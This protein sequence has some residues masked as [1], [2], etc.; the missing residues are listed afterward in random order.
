MCWYLHM[1]LDKNPISF[2]CLWISSFPTPFIK[3]T[4]LFYYM[5]L[6]SLLRINRPYTHRFV[7]RFS[8]LFHWLMCLFL[9]WYQYG[10]FHTLQDAPHML[11][12]YQDGGRMCF[13]V[14]NDQDRVPP[15]RQLPVCRL[16]C[17]VSLRI[18]KDPKFV[19]QTKVEH[20]LKLQ[21]KY[22]NK[23]KMNFPWDNSIFIRLNGYSILLCT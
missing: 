9:G 17:S 15:K 20:I 3:Q 22:Q 10:I 5:F 11:C 7:S 2:F 21:E 13:D 6:A 12:I 16:N 1:V 19:S 23:K 4:V 14:S 8:I 18:S